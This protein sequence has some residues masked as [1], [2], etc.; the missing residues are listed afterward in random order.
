MTVGT[1]VVALKQGGPPTRL[2][3]GW[4]QPDEQVISPVGQRVCAVARRGE[5]QVTATVNGDA[6]ALLLACGPMLLF[7]PIARKLSPGGLR[8]W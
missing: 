7:S 6:D 4:Q 1:R 8:L 3:C 5:L 2:Q